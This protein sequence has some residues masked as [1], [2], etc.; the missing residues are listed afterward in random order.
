MTNIIHLN[1]YSI[2]KE[3][4]K[5]IIFRIS[6]YSFYVVYVIFIEILNRVIDLK[7]LKFNF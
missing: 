3:I 5:L 1:N 4:N 2:L 6:Y 7:F